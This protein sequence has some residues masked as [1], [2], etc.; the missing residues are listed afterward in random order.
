MMRFQAAN[1]WYNSNLDCNQKLKPLRVEGPLL[2]WY[3]CEELTH[4]QQ[5]PQAQ[6]AHEK[7]PTIRLTYR[8]TML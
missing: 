5:Q 6:N 1:G 8:V 2:V 7:K 4:S 3:E